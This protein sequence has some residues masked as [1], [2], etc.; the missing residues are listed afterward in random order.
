VH[1]KTLRR[2]R[3]SVPTPEAISTKLAAKVTG[4]NSGD[5]PLLGSAVVVAVAVGLAVAVA[6]GLAEAVTVD[7]ALAVAVAVALAVAVAVG[8]VVPPP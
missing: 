1:Y 2:T 8:L 7:I 6:V 4:N 5:P 3:S